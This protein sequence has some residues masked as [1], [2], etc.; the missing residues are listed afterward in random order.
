MPKNGT[1]DHHMLEGDNHDSMASD[2]VALQDAVVRE[3]S[4]THPAD[5]DIL[6]L[7]EQAFQKYSNRRPKRLVPD[8]H[9]DEHYWQKRKKNNDAAR[10]SRDLKRQKE[11]TLRQSMTE[12][13]RVN[14]LLSEELKV[15]KAAFNLS[16]NKVYLGLSS[17]GSLLYSPKPS[18][19]TMAFAEA[20]ES[21]YDVSLA[22]RDIEPQVFSPNGYLKEYSTHHPRYPDRDIHGKVLRYQDIDNPQHEPRQIL[23]N[24]NN[25]HTDLVKY[26]VRSRLYQEK[27]NGFMESDDNRYVPRP[28][29]EL[30]NNS[31]HSSNSPKVY[32]PDATNI[33]KTSF[34][35]FPQYAQQMKTRLSTD[36]ARAVQVETI[37][38]P[39]GRPP[40]PHQDKANER[41]D[42]PMP[43][44]ELLKERLVQRLPSKPCDCH[45]MHEIGSDR[46]V[47]KLAPAGYN[48]EMFQK[49]FQDSEARRESVAPREGQG[50]ES[51]ANMYN[52]HTKAPMYGQHPPPNFVGVSRETQKLYN[53]AEL[54][55]Y[56]IKHRN[57]AYMS[58]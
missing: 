26:Q 35:I 43:A 7:D 38:Q 5:N 8:D 16:E 32:S 36:D 24:S 19:P 31:D 9:K 55:A 48:R 17:D 50:R 37:E 21:Q 45:R 20:R 42:Q 15:L 4:T 34:P 12:L 22:Q 2:T 30:S 25:P 44:K 27:L 39:Y 1:V 58:Q 49:Y 56:A 3:E 10:K 11:N 40:W 6:S 23:G 54:K 53:M 46:E 13:Q 41:R 14:I 18:N 29:S 28:S 47:P 57:M 51:G 52:V 33:C